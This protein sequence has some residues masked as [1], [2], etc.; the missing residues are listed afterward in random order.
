M[1]PQSAMKLLASINTFR[2]NHPKFAGF[3]QL[4]LKR[5]LDEGTVIEVTVTRP[6]EDP[7]TSN[8]KVTQSDIELFGALKD[9]G[10]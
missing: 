6:G 8:M 2:T 9:L 4:M 3:V 5:G 7:I 10:V 1:N